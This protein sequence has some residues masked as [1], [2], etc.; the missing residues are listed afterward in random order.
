MIPIR[1]RALGARVHAFLDHGATFDVQRC[2][3]AAHDI[4]VDGLPVREA[5]RLP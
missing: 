1:D 3:D 4:Q 5:M 2:S